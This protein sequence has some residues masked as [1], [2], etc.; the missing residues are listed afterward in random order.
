MAY[1]SACNLRY[2][3]EFP[4]AYR[5]LGFLAMRALYCTALALASW[6]TL[7]ISRART[8]PAA[9]CPP[10]PLI[11]QITW[12]PTET[13]IRKA[14]DSDNWPMTWADNDALYTAYGD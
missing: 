13:I 4:P 1:C 3:T 6:L 9:P 2:A 5:S 11:R 12:S 7:P 10:S 14:H 8:T